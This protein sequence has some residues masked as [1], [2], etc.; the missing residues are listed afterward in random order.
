MIYHVYFEH[1]KN[2]YADESDKK[3]FAEVIKNSDDFFVFI[4]AENQE[5]DWNYF[6]SNYGLKEYIQFKFA[7]QT[8]NINYPSL[9]RRLMMYILSTK[10]LEG[11]EYVPGTFC[12]RN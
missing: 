9:G 2:R 5:T 7:R 4:I 10:K 11:N 3:K 6:V 12:G 1:V 8:T